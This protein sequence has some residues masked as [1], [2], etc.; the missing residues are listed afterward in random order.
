MSWFFG[1]LS[2]RMFQ[3]SRES[4]ESGRNSS[5]AAQGHAFTLMV[6]DV[7]FFSLG[8]VHCLGQSC[9]LSEYNILHR[10]PVI[11]PES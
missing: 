10:S 7:T 9:E 6:M 1:G 11:T 8:G 5:C 3:K 2:S 4:P